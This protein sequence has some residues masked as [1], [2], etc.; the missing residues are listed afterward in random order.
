[1]SLADIIIPGSRNNDVSVALI[2]NH[3]KNLTKQFGQL[4][5]KMTTILYFGDILYQVDG[6]MNKTI[7]NNIDD[8]LY[9][10]K[11]N[12]QFI[13]PTEELTK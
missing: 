4:K 1:M 10:K 2:V 5:D 3:L 8:L 9:E 7:K 11:V 13:F 12:K 6:L